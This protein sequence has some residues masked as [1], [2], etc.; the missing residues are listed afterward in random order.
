M[1]EVSELRNNLLNVLPQLSGCIKYGLGANTDKWLKIPPEQK[2][3]PDLT[4]Y[5]QYK[6]LCHIEVSGSN[7]IEMKRE[8]KI[9]IRPDKL[10]SAQRSGI[11][12]WFYMVYRNCRCVLDAETVSRYRNNITTAYI[13]DGYN[14][15][16]IPE[17]YIAV[18]YSE[19]DDIGTMIRWLIE[20]VG[21]KHPDMIDKSQTTIFKFGKN[22]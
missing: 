14:G 19:A 21:R 9:W 6:P 1:E 3:E 8:S 22:I 4:I 11:K 2:G 18:P 13:K 17:Q 12:C 7:K 16:K 10:Y 15:Q 20:K 5:W